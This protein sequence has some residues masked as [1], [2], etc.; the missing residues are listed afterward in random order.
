[1]QYKIMRSMYTITEIKTVS[2]PPKKCNPSNPHKTRSQG[3]WIKSISPTEIHANERK[4][5]IIDDTPF[6]KASNRPGRS[7]N[8]QTSQPP[9]RERDDDTARAPRR[10]R[11]RAI[12]LGCRY[13]AAETQP[14]STNGWGKAFTSARQL[15]RGGDVNEATHYRRTSQSAGFALL[16]DE[17]INARRIGLSA[18]STPELIYLPLSLSPSRNFFR[19]F[20]PP[21][22]LLSP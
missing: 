15:P 4:S 16:H 20:A 6:L 19:L 22:G 17:T 5:I 13:A 9:E 18:A 3:N 21:R 12:L 7:I 10:Q 1:M 2:Q 11:G 8:R 14:E